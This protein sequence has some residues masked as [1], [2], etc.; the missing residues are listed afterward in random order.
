[1]TSTHEHHTLVKTQRRNYKK[2]HDS[3]GANFSYG[4]DAQALNAASLVAAQNRVELTV[5]EG[6]DMIIANHA[7]VDLPQQ[8]KKPTTR[9]LNNDQIFKNLIRGP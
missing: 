5:D 1:M 4:T 8:G 9:Q 3:E 6:K 2:L 7:M